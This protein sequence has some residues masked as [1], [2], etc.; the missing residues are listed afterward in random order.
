[1]EQAIQKLQSSAAN[2]AQDYAKMRQEFTN[3]AYPICHTEPSINLKFSTVR[4][5]DAIL[6]QESIPAN[7]NVTLNCFNCDYWMK[8]ASEQ[9][10]THS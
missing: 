9:N 5:V 10:L 7:K 3:L 8:S 4:G 6:I 2:A 1:V